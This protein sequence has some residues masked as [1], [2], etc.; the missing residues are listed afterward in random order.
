MGYGWFFGAVSPTFAVIL[1]FTLIISGYYLIAQG[2]ERS[3]DA[4]EQIINDVF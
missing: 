2:V 1:T 3:Y 4:I